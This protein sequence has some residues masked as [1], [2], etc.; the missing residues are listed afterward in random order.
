[1]YQI[2]TLAPEAIIGTLPVTNREMAQNLDIFFQ[3]PFPY[4]LI[5]DVVEMTFIIKATWSC[6][7]LQHLKGKT[8]SAHLKNKYIIFEYHTSNGTA[9]L[10]DK[11]NI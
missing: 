11:H 5:N 2:L 9:A 10:G 4:L 1:M 7:L 6:D 3:V 8:T